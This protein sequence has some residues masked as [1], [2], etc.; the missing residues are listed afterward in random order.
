MDTMMH[1]N[2]AVQ[3]LASICQPVPKED[4]NGLLQFPRKE[5]EFQKIVSAAL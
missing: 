3:M 2:I 1:N 5:C 4:I